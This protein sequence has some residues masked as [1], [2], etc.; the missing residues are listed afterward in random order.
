MARLHEERAAEIRAGL[1]VRGSP[2]TPGPGVS[3]SDSESLAIRGPGRRVVT[4]RRQMAPVEEEPSPSQAGGGN[5]GAGR[6]VQVQRTQHGGT[7]IRFGGDGDDSS[8][9]RGR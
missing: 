3:S 4:P 2:L 1:V 9:S 5:R 7:H 8:T 6:G